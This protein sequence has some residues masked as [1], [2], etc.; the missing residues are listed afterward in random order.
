MA[1]A[2][3]QRRGEVR[4]DDLVQEGNLGLLR[5]AEKFDPHAGTRFSTYAVWWI[6]AHM[7]EFILRS[8]SLVRLGTTQ[9]QRKLFFALART[10]RE[11]LRADGEAP[12]TEQIAGRLR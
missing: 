7:Q 1:V 2:C 8:W 10:K 12:S 11:M 6:R 4:L 9:G 5:A 3:K